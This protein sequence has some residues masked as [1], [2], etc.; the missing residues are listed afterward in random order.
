MK[1]YILLLFISFIMLPVCAQQMKIGYFSYNAVLKATPDYLTATAN[2]ENLKKQYDAEIQIAQKDFNEKYENFIENQ[3]G[4]ASAIREKRQSELQSILERN[5]AFKQES[6]RLLAKAEEE[7]L[8]PLRAKLDNAIKSLGSEKDFIVILN[9][10]NN[11]APYINPVL[12]ED[13]TEIL[14]SKIR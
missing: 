14:I 10:D 3:D 1:K 11:A 2:I 8:A 6:E 9:T 7:A 5:M 4:M 12:G 13:V